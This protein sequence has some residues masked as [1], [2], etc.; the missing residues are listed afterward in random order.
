M[1]KKTSFIV[2]D[3]AMQDIA[4]PARII[5]A[6]VVATFLARWI[7]LGNKICPSQVRG[8]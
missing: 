8:I 4:S 2:Q 7:I 3:I 6:R 5:L 1:C